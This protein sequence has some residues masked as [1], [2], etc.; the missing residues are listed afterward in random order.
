MKERI[1]EGKAHLA[2]TG[3][4]QKT[5][6]PD[7][8]KETVLSAKGSLRNSRDLSN[9]QGFPSPETRAPEKKFGSRMV[10][11]KPEVVEK[12]VL[13]SKPSFP[14]S[15]PSTPKSVPEPRPLPVKKSSFADKFNPGL[16]GMLMRG[17][18]PM[19]GPSANKPTASVAIKQS[20]PTEPSGPLKHVG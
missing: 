19:G 4:P 2:A 3:G 1:L 16:A 14:K 10:E 20:E 17:P 11:T 8:L 18:P 15:E 9:F 12:P 7:P 6:R 13:A 5:V